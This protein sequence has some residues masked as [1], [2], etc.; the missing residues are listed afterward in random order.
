MTYIKFSPLLPTYIILLI[1]LDLLSLHA[2]DRLKETDSQNASQNEHNYNDSPHL[3]AEMT[4]ITMISMINCNS[5]IQGICDGL[6]VSWAS[7]FIVFFTP[8]PHLRDS[9]RRLMRKTVL[10]LMDL[11]FP[12]NQNS[13]SLLRMSAICHYLLHPTG[14]ARLELAKND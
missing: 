14:R 9:L 2:R 10:K 6:V 3:D 1:R 7:R 11:N 8:D 13:V 5:I 4:I 12:W